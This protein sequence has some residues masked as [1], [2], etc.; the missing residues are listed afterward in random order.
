MQVRFVC[1]DL[2]FCNRSLDLITSVKTFFGSK[3][4]SDS[5]PRFVQVCKVEKRFL[6]YGKAFNKYSVSG[7]NI[8]IM[9]NTLRTLL[10][11]TAVFFPNSGLKCI[12]F[13]ELMARPNPLSI[14]QFIQ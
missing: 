4:V 5:L 13:I 9:E 11:A 1:R 12:L 8:K 3:T 10:Q 7:S 2:L 14:D 6:L